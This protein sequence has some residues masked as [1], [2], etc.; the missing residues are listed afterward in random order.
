MGIYRHGHWSS[1]SCSFNFQQPDMFIG[2]FDCK[3]CVA[4]RKL[5]PNSLDTLTS[6]R[7]TT[8]LGR[9]SP[10]LP[11]YWDQKDG[12]FSISKNRKNV[13][14]FKKVTVCTS[15]TTLASPWVLLMLL[16]SCFDLL[17]STLWTIVNCVYF[18]RIQAV[19]KVILQT[20]ISL[21]CLNF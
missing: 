16:V 14:N 4:V 2:I 13:L 20:L 19:N 18:W 21:L 8:E 7:I 5:V 1:R 6:K 3:N 11:R 12:R 10:C 17:I 9:S 15:F